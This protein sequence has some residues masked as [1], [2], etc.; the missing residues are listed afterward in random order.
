MT[1]AFTRTWLPTEWLDEV[2]PEP[3]ADPSRFVRRMDDGSFELRA[4]D[5]WDDPECW[6]ITVSDGQTINM[7]AY[8]DFGTIEVTIAEDGSFT[9]EQAVPDGAT[10]FWLD[11]EPDTM[12]GSL[13][14]MVAN[15]LLDGRADPGRQTIRASSWQHSAIFQ[16]RIDA[17]GAGRLV[18]EGTVQ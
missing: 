11:G 4:P 3:Q 17:A 16:F 1:E 10:Q 18:R 12:G 5:D 6:R 13:T 8:D 9:A 15:L 7:S 14:E 2:V